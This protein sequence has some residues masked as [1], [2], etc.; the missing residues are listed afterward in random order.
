MR[1]RER[2]V[3]QRGVRAAA[4]GRAALFLALALGAA[5][6]ALPFWW[7][8]S[9]SLQ[10]PAEV[11]DWPPHWWPPAP[12]WE[13]YARVMRVVPFG[14]AVLNTLILIVPP[15]GVGLL[16]S[17]LAGY[18]FARL[19]FPG[20]EALF[21]LLLATLMIPGAV[22]LVPLFILFRELRWVDSFR[23][24]IVP[25]LFGGA[26]AIFLMRQH[27]RSLPSELEDAARVDGCNP[28]QAFRLVMLP[29]AKPP[30][31][32]LAL[33]GFLGGWN[34]FLG[35]LIYLHSAEKFPLQLVLAEFQSLYYRDWTLIM[36]GAALASLPP[37]ALFLVGQR[38]F[39]EGIA[40][41]GLKG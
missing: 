6:T 29:L 32:T 22:T 9:T 8:V 1:N 5:A 14:R 4:L 18:A 39:V 11:Y 2:S 27:F 20:R 21:G 40:V 10:R 17:A 25:G 28:W 3:R 23:P 30:V 35:P 12:Q 33:L 38:S 16:A 24:L 13:N 41:T 7:M 19:R 26:Y 37:I 34:E 31:I 15:L 36:A